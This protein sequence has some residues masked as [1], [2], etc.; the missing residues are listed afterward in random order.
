LEFT[1]RQG[2]IKKMSDDFV[3]NQNR[4]AALIKRYGKE[5]VRRV[6]FR[7][8]AL[9]DWGIKLSLPFLATTNAM[10]D[11][12]VAE[13]AGMSVD[14]TEDG[15][16]EAWFCEEG[17]DDLFAVPFQP[18]RDLEDA[19]WASR[20]VELHGFYYVT[21]PLDVCESILELT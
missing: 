18:S 14:V 1:I 6:S 20:I 11:Y 5:L 3:D 4:V 9:R 13:S 15:R 17:S 10:L 7:E 2:R 16:V 21:D 12:L 8:K 19:L